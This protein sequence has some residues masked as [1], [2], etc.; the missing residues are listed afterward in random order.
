[1]TGIRRR[2]L[3]WLTGD[4]SRN[5]IAT[6]KPVRQGNV[7]TL[8]SL[9]PRFVPKYHAVYLDLLE[10][11]L[12][13]RDTRSVALTG[14]FGSGKSSVLRAIPRW[15]WSRQ[16][17]WLH[18]REIVELTLATLDPGL[19][20]TT[21]ATNP[22]EKEMSNRIQKELVKQMLYRLPARRTPRSRFPRA[23][24][25]SWREWSVAAVAGVATVG[26]GWIVVALSGWQEALTQRLDEIGWPATWFWGLAAAASVV[27]ALVS[28]RTFAG[29]YALQ[30]GISAGAVTLSLQPT[31]SSY[32]DQYLDEIMYFFQVSRA[33][34]VLIEDVDRFSDAVVFDTLRALNSLVNSSGQVK[35]RVVFVYAIRDSVLGE[36]GAKKDLST[37]VSIGVTDSDPVVQALD[38][39]NRAK[40]FDVVIPIIRVCCT[41]R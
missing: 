1:M 35:R 24:R 15:Y 27:L 7:M 31:S 11:A 26:I 8:V 30:A 9:A 13:H 10:R 4:R 25:S 29:R 28:W 12:R 32:F 21:Q 14:S 33:N 20:P 23:S 41:D 36:I 34:V 39:S 17:P 3:R 16:V 5:V 22:A 19:A 6:R 37:T 2:V 38:R 40:Y 18:R